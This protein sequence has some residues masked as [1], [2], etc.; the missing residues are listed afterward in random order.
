MTPEHHLEYN[1]TPVPAQVE[2]LNVQEELVV[3]NTKI[4]F[5]CHEPNSRELLVLMTTRK[6]LI[7][8][9]VAKGKCQ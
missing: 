4:L 5:Y 8:N 1:V 2:A 3:R 6:K 9:L 7:R